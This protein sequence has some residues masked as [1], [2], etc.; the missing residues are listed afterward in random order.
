M[1]DHKIPYYISMITLLL[2]WALLIHIT[3]LGLYP[4]E[5]LV[6]NRV[7]ILGDTF[8]RGGLL[9]YEID[10]CKNM[11]ISATVA[12]HFEDGILYRLRSEESHLEKGCHVKTIALEIPHNMPIGKYKL[13]SSATY[14]VNQIRDITVKYSTEEFE[15]IE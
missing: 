10:F 6:I 13:C 7:T 12:K 9:M 15:V 8:Q 11:D 1:K 4:Y 14:H 3:W 5:P 2:A